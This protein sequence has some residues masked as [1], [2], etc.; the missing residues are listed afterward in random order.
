M[1]YNQFG[2]V[3][4]VNGLTTG[5]HLGA[6]MQDAIDTAE[7]NKP[8]ATQT[9]T[10]TRVSNT[11]DDYN[12]PPNSGK[13]GA[14][15]WDDLEG[16]PFGEPCLV[17]KVIVEPTTINGKAGNIHEVSS[18][19]LEEGGTYS[20]VWDEVK[21]DCTCYNDSGSR[22]A[23][24]N[25]SISGAGDDTG[26]A[27]CFFVENGFKY[28][29]AQTDGEHSFS[30]TQAIEAVTP[31][32]TE[33]LPESLRFGTDRG[34]G[35]L[36]KQQ[37]CGSGG[38]IPFFKM[39]I[40]E[41]YTVIL[42]GTRYENLVCFDY[43]GCPIIGAPFE[44]YT[45][46]PFT[47]SL[48]EDGTIVSLRFEADE[49]YFRDVEVL[50]FYET[51]TPINEKYLHMNDIPFFVAPLDEGMYGKNYWVFPVFENVTSY[52]DTLA[53]FEQADNGDIEPLT[54]YQA[55]YEAVYNALEKGHARMV[56]ESGE[57][58]TYYQP[59][60]CNR[61]NDGNFTVTFVDWEFSDP[62]SFTLFKFSTNNLG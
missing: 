16:K 7:N 43:E 18:L 58:V 30:V 10:V 50:G 57:G 49:P 44:Q 54:K 27:F 55:H 31:I 13:G 17:E 26:E 2:E 22:L 33:M 32:P 46:Y 28:V 12:P 20:V 48:E 6:P 42:N 41:V 38:S 37:Q 24:G 36:S 61:T 14:S 21:V 39:K 8:Y 35:T 59:F 29:V 23:L 51:I 34:Y 60:S 3:V 45:E 11:I 25:V 53:L 47:I 5:Q 1:K 52:D 40:G 15:H 4:S 62:L 19:I 9:N 56:L